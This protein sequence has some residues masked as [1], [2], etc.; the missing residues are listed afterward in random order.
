VTKGSR[1]KKQ[2]EHV[3]AQA[4]I[5]APPV[6]VVGIVRS[7][8]I[9]L[10][11]GP[12]PNDLSGF[13]LHQNDEA[14]IG[15]NSLHSRTRQRFTLAHEFGHYLLHP[16]D[17]FVDRKFILFR[18]TLSS[19]AIDPREKEANEFAAT[20]LMPERFLRKLLAGEAVDLEDEERVSQ[21]AKTFGVSNQALVFRLINLDLAQR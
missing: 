7:R 1:A 13:L 12:L 6:D 5:S 4:K 18:N 19:Q 10:R 15:V 11:F 16:S 2:A 21:L 9:K 17:N 8:D 14:L 20:L 3:L